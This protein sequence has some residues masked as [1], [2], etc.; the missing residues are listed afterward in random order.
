M[1]NFITLR[2]LDFFDF[3]YKK[4]ILNFLKSLKLQNLD[5][6][7]DVGAHEGEMQFFFLKNF[8]VKKIISFEASEIN[9]SK[10][11]KEC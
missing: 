5:V 6:V 9:F 2:I 7:F 11:K 4:K 8:N 10:L 1:I 3:F